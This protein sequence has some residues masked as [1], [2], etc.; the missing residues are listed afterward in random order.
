[1]GAFLAQM[2]FRHAVI[3]DLGVTDGRFVDFT[4]LA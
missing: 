3:D 1:M 2:D 4:D